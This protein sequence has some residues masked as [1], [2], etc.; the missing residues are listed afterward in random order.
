MGR[1]YRERVWLALGA[2]LALGICGFAVARASIGAWLL[3]RMF[4][5]RAGVD[6][7]ASL[8]DGLHVALCGTGSPL[9]DPTRAGP[10]SVVI[11]GRHIFV[12][13]AGEGGARTMGLMTIPHGDIDALFLTHLHSDHIDGLNPIA[14]MRWTSGARTTPLPV[15]GPAG[16]DRVVAGFNA[17]YAIDDGFRTAH[18]GTRVA[19]PSGAGSTAHVFAAPPPGSLDPVVVYE[20]DGV[21]VTAFRVVHPPVEPAVGYRFDYKGRSVVFSGDTTAAPALVRAARGADLL[22]HEGLSPRLTALMTRSLDGRNAPVQQITRD[23]LDYHADP[24]M[25]A[26]EAQRAGVRNLVFSHTIPSMPIRIAYPAFLGDARSRF[27]GTI[28]VG[29]DGMLF[30]LPAGQRGMAFS[31]YPVR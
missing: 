16:T 12:V 26:A 20:G 15:Y 10:C 19:P 2:A 30:S 6:I 4:D 17:A 13:D 27:S 29:E 8:P 5:S 24:A 21:R 7:R 1:G 22:V 9:P 3:G 31:R 18:H 14:L 23:I 11:A 25:A 28:I